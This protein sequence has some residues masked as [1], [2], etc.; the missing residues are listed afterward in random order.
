REVRRLAE[1]GRRRRMEREEMM[2]REAKDEEAEERHE[3]AAPVGECY[4]DVRESA[5]PTDL[6]RSVTLRY[7]ASAAFQLDRDALLSLWERFGPIQDCVLREK[8]MKKDGEKHR[9]PYI[10]AILV[11]KSIVG[12]HAAISDIHKLQEI[13]AETWG[14][15]EAVGWASGKEPECVP[16]PATP[17]PQARAERMGMNG[18]TTA[19][20]TP[21]RNGDAGK[22]GAGLKK[23]PSF[24]SF[25][26]TPAGGTPKGANSPSLD[27]ITM[28]RL[29]NAERRRLEEKIRREEAAGA[30]EG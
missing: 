6:D 26:G 28:I 3:D 20:S 5:G 17:V 14:I 11:Y 13:D 10:T 12:A 7:P 8:K 15:F 29:K 25:K 4:G 23:A 2:R 18:G 1:D 21:L 9:Q 22:N 24:A 19:P 30:A 16:K 27:E